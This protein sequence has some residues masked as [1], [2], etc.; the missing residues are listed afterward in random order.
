MFSLEDRLEVEAIVK[1][2][3]AYSIKSKKTGDTPRE[4]YDLVNKG[5]T[6]ATASAPGMNTTIQA[7]F[8]PTLIPLS[9]A[10]FISGV[11]LL[12]GGGFKIVTGGQ[13]LVI[14]VAF[15]NNP[16]T[17]SKFDTLIYV[18]GV[19]ALDAPAY[20]TATGN[21]TAPFVAGILNL[22]TGDNVQLYG[23]TGSASTQTVST[24]SYL[25][26]AKV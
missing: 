26:I 14:G 21:Y 2:I 17:V 1:N 18:N 13:Y 5:F 23:E 4:K 12:T 15:F 3:L 9:T 25:S 24:S 19:M 11:T 8:S 20:N 6:Y 22:K 7:S 10:T 16:S